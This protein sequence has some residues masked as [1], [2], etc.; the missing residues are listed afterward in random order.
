MAAD[1]ELWSISCLA[2]DFSSFG[3]EDFV[4]LLSLKISGA[5]SYHPYNFKTS[6]LILF[7]R[8]HI[9]LRQ[10]NNHLQW[11]GE[12]TSQK[13]PFY[14]FNHLLVIDVS[15]IHHWNS[16]H[17]R[18]LFTSAFRY[19]YFC[20]M[21]QLHPSLQQDHFLTECSRWRCLPMVPTA[22]NQCAS[23]FIDSVRFLFLMLQSYMTVYIQLLLKLIKKRLLEAENSRHWNV[24]CI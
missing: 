18:N 14:L 21:Y 24:L 15:V 8:Y 11:N 22:Q 17:M 5:F 3:N 4:C 9:L 2:R 16:S 10:L 12:G 1:F 23:A 20:R 19:Y 13:N 7:Q 6:V